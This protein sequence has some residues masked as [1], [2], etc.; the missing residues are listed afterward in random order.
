MSELQRHL[1]RIT[2]S[3]GYH[4]TIMNAHISARDWENDPNRPVVNIY[5]GPESY[6]NANDIDRSLGVLNKRATVFLDCLLRETDDPTLERTKFQADLERYFL[7]DNNF[8]LPDTAGSP[9]I[10]N[11]MFVNATPYGDEQTNQKIKLEMETVIWYRTIL[12]DP[13]QAH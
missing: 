9:T 2:E 3:N 1:L 11:M 12:G 10:F 5:W 13:Y 4:N 8:N 7:N 6:L